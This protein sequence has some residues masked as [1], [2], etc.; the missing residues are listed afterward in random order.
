MTDQTP[1]LEEA[2]ETLTARLSPEGRQTLERLDAQEVEHGISEGRE[3]I[4]TLPPAERGLVFRILEL[5]D[6]DEV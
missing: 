5:R 1:S 4:W 6:R 3:L 2:V